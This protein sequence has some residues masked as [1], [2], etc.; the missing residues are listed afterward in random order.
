MRL[1]VLYQCIGCERSYDSQQAASACPCDDKVKA[2]YEC[3]GCKSVDCF[4]EICDEPECSQEAHC[5]FPT[6]GGGYRRTCSK[7]SML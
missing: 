6:P 4:V 5:G 7:H 1:R 2:L 3:P